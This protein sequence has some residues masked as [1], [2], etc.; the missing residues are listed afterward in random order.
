[1]T[2]NICI[3]QTEREGVTNVVIDTD[4]QPVSFI[5]REFPSFK[6]A[7]EYAADLSNHLREG[8]LEV[9]LTRQWG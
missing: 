4:D 3:W 9:N 5:L 2:L 8:G 1:M 6:E 7:E